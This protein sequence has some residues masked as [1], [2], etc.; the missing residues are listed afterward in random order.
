M[1]ELEQLGVD[2]V[3]VHDHAP[4]EVLF[5]IA[6][7]TQKVGLPFAGHFPSAVSVEEAADPDIRS[8]EHLANYRA[9]GDC[10][11]GETV[12]FSP[13]ARLFEKLAAKGV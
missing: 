1:Y 13:C 7:E 9:F 4:C 3:K 6:E 2:F 12:D 11:T 8:I 10:W 5:V